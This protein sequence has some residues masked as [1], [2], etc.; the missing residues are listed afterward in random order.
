MSKLS[1]RWRR[2]RQFVHEWMGVRYELDGC[3]FT[4]PP[5]ADD[6]K[7]NIRRGH[8]E[9]AERRLVARWL[10]GE[11]AMVELGGAFG[12]LS[13]AIGAR[14]HAD[15]PH[16]VV[17]ANP[18]LVAFC[19]LNATAA[20]Q[21]DAPVT[22]VHAAIAYNCGNEAD[23]IPSGAFLGSRLALPG[24]AG[25]IKVPVTTLAQVLAAHVPDRDFDLVCDI[26]GAE[27]ELLLHDAGSLSRCYLAIIE[28]HP[29]VFAAK[30]SSEADFV[31]LLGSAGFEIVD[32]DENV[33]VARN[34]NIGGQ[35]ES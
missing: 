21:A 7:R 1:R 10:K 13:G 4:L 9:A 33:I 16:I 28:L 32:R 2:V 5:W 6:V 3:S 31:A 18:K 26:E 12:I 24:E 22:A 20:R 34:R 23:F 15:T 8:Y 17:E 25:A 11:R 19:R 14:L 27:L 29:D 35:S 30:G